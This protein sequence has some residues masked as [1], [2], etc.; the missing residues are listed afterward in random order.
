[1]AV[2][3]DCLYRIWERVKAPTT[4]HSLPANIMHS[5]YPVTTQ[6][7]EIVLA[8]NKKEGKIKTRD[9]NTI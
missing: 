7:T 3:I 1:M 6:G 4:S 2:Q 8:H 5:S 9:T